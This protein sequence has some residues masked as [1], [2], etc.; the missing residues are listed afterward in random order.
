MTSGRVGEC[1]AARS[2]ADAV[3]DDHGIVITTSTFLSDEFFHLVGSHHPTDDTRN[4][5]ILKSILRDGCV[6]YPKCIP[7]ESHAS[8]SVFRNRSLASGKM[9]VPTCT[10]Y[11]DIPLDSLGFHATKY[12]KFGLSFSRHMLIRRGARPVTYLPMREDDNLSVHGRTLLDDIQETY[13]AFSTYFA[14]PRRQVKSSRP[15]GRRPDT[16]DKTIVALHS[17]L[18][19][20]LLAFIKPYNEELPVDHPFIFNR[21]ASGA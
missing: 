2:V 20:K 7:G 15:V 19:F 8:V 9:F 11:C 21:N 3:S 17:V 5:E 13:R 6:K 18:I 4:F 1:A 12:G 16:E 14:E 10:C